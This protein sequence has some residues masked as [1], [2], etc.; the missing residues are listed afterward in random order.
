MLLKP[1]ARKLKGETRLIIVHVAEYASG[2]VATYLRN[3]IELQESDEKISKIYL[4]VSDLKSE[5]FEFSNKVSV[6]RYKYSRSA[7]GLFQLLLLS[8]K[9]E[10][11]EPDVIHM[12]STFAGLLRMFLKRRSNQRL[13]YCAHGWAFTQQTSNLKKSV[14]A[15]C[16]RLLSTRTD[17]IINIS[18]SEENAARKRKISPDKMVTILNT[19]SLEDND[20][21]Q[22]ASSSALTLK[23]TMKQF[24]FVGRFDHQKG[25]D[26]LLDAVGMSNH[27]FQLDVIGSSVLSDENFRFEKNYKNSNMVHFLGWKDNHGVQLAMNRCDA[28][29]IP[30][31][32]EGFGLVALE[33]MRSN[34]AVIASDVGGLSEIVTP[35][36]TGILFPAGD[37]E[38]LAS[39][40]NQVSKNQLNIMGRAGYSKLLK[41]YSPVQMEKEILALYK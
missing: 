37:T 13:V 24:L 39:I 27:E 11:I 2:G 20:K 15:L 7:Y 19:I 35:S 3:L 28:V 38:A 1:R 31:R 6:V 18:M 41:K 9:I 25:L 5:Q 4:F 21:A 30:S 22:E 33:A 29:I 32:W 10:K 23:E 8:R 36:V 26:I 34:C 40:L 12:H 17:K 14:Y 16:E